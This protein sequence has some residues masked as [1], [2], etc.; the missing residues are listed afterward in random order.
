M[1]RTP[2]VS[3]KYLPTYTWMSRRIACS[4]N[5]QPPKGEM[6]KVYAE[7]LCNSMTPASEYLIWAAAGSGVQCPRNG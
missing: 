1:M 6:A 2:K 7:I 5:N 3:F 4:N